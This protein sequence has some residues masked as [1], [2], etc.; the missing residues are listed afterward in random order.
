ML[1][2]EHGPTGVRTRMRHFSISWYGRVGR[3]IDSF[4]IAI[5]KVR[6]RLD[7][8]RKQ[9]AS[10]KGIPAWPTEPTAAEL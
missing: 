9:A 1:H 4:D 8:C 3:P 2:E 10:E 6:E 7:L 5:R